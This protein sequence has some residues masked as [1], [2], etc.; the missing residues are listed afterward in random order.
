MYTISNTFI[1]GL[2][3]NNTIVGYYSAAEKIIKAVQDH[4]SPISQTI[5]PY[6]SKLATESR[7]LALVLLKKLL[8]ITGS[9]YFVISTIMIIFAQQIIFF[10]YGTGYKDSIIIFR[11]LS[12]IPLILSFSTVYATLFLL[13][14]GYK[15]VWSS[16]IITA[17]LTQVFL[18]VVFV[19]IFSMSSLGISLA[20]VV[21]ELY[22]LIC[23]YIKFRRFIYADR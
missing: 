22:I 21:T 23:S 9:V 3:T 6:I 18:D 1:L 5:Y 17:S 14:F 8:R 13:G 11:V 19:Y 2:F 10:L 7:K 20:Y 15:K 4:L 12:F 16:I